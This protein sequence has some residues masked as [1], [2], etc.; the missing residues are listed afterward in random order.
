MNAVRT[1]A[2]AF[3]LLG[4]SGVLAA[5]DPSQDRVVLVEKGG[6][7]RVAVPVSGV[8]LTIPKGQL[9]PSKPGTGSDSPRYFSFEDRENALIF[10]GWFE[11]EASF[12][13]IDAFWA[14]EQQSLKQLGHPIE[15]VARERV[16][17]WQLVFYDIPIPGGHS[18]NVRAEMTVAGAWIDLH[19]SVTGDQSQ[20]QGRRALREAVKGI[21]VSKQEAVR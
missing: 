14:A 10:S 5:Q 3:L 9:V 15:N 19:I 11:P 6:S 2:L 18:F 20:A 8:A 16:G 7:Y 12:P 17:D 13:G 21:Q 4:L 1:C